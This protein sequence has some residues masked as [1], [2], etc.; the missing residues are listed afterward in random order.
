MGKIKTP[1]SH[2][3]VHKMTVPENQT[4]CIIRTEQIVLDYLKKP[5]FAGKELLAF[6]KRGVAV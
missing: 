1:E 6:T 4:V 2:L 3:M 5:T